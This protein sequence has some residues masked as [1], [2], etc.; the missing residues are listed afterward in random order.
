M[1]KGARNMKREINFIVTKFRYVDFKML[2]LSAD[3]NLI[4]HFSY[5]IVYK[6]L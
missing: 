2:M 6:G 5:I 4:C 1:E 3:E